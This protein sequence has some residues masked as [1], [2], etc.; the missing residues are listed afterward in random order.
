MAVKAHPRKGRKGSLG[1]ARAEGARRE[2]VPTT[3]KDPGAE[4]AVAASSALNT[5]S[6]PNGVKG[7]KVV[8]LAETPLVPREG[9]G[10]APAPVPAPERGSYDGD[11]AIKLY[12]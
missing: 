2:V 10:A 8:E 5:P 4:P 3:E 7:Q 11:T 12:L 6:E 1:A 9:Q